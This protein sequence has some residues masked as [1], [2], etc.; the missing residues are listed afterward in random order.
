MESRK[1]DDGDHYGETKSRNKEYG[2][3]MCID[4]ED[5][6][7][8]GQKLSRQG[9]GEVEKRKPLLMI[10]EHQRRRPKSTYSRNRVGMSR[11]TKWKSVK[12][13][14]RN[15]GQRWRFTG[16]YGN[17]DATQRNHSWTLLRRLAGMTDWPWLFMGDFNEIMFDSEK[18]GGAKKKWKELANFC[19]A[20]ED[21]KLMD[22]GYRGPTFT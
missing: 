14:K 11:K 20:V 22:M 15:G 4:V 12:G 19:E 8:E 9:D 7:G 17:P 21:C 1:V 6:K 18:Y 5:I 3:V 10:S 16:F 13:A 2:V